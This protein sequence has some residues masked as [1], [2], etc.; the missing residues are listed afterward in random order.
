MPA[1]LSGHLVNTFYQSARPPQ[2]HLPFHQFVD[3]SLFGQL[4]RSSQ[5]GNDNIITCGRASF[6]ASM[7]GRSAM[8]QS[9]SFNSS[10]VSSSYYGVDALSMIND[11]TPS[12]M[13][14]SQATAAKIATL[15]AKLNKKLGPEYISQR[16]G[17]GGGPKLTY[18]EVRMPGLVNEG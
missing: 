7:H 1:S 17:P 2:S 13:D 9:M 10:S 11:P 5:P 12:Y 4:G 14:L 6:N 8:D 16:P 15:Q 3:N 18:A